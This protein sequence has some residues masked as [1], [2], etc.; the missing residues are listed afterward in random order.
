MLLCVGILRV[1]GSS[2]LTSEANQGLCK[3]Q[4]GYQK[5]LL[6]D[7]AQWFFSI[8]CAG[9]TLGHVARC[10]RASADA[11]PELVDCKPERRE[12]ILRARDL[13]PSIS[14]EEDK[15]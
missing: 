8:A 2:W 1:K 12:D 5:V 11:D 14:I 10:R 7:K 3:R 13:F 9:C 15:K 4:V 6:F